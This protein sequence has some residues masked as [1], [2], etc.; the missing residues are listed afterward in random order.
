MRPSDLQGQG[1]GEKNKMLSV[2]FMRLQGAGPSEHIVPCIYALTRSAGESHAPVNLQG[3]GR[4]Q[5][6]YRI[7]S[8][9]YMTF[10][11][12]GRWCTNVQQRCA[13]SPDAHALSSTTVTRHPL[14]PCPNRGPM[15]GR[16]GWALPGAWLRKPH[17]ARVMPDPW[18]LYHYKWCLWWGAGDQRS[19]LS[20]G[21]VDRVHG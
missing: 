1:R 17:P 3:Q 19:C 16:R 4:R 10:K 6:C 15:V 2:P 8:D 18:A 21:C 7:A 9:P 13:G 14:G 20:F 5:V 12:R 11:A